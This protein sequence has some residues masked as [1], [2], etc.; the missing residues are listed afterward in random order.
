MNQRRTRLS[1]ANNTRDSFTAITKRAGHVVRLK[2]YELKAFIAPNLASTQDARIAVE[3]LIT[4][5]PD[6]P[7]GLTTLETLNNRASTIDYF[8]FRKN[9]NF[10]TNGGS[11]FDMKWWS[12]WHTC[13]LW[14]PEIYML[15]TQ[16][17]NADAIDGLQ[18]GCTI[19]YEWLKV[20]RV[21]YLEV[22]LMW[23]RDEVDSAETAGGLPAR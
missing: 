2:G 18:W 9:T 14:L 4:A 5:E 19:E 1:D 3:L 13:D 17:V 15:K 8:R 16:S 11:L 22:A 12:G 21:T 6:F 10:S 20:S 7:S 23:G